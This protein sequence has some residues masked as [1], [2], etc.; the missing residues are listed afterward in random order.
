[1]AKSSIHIKPIKIGSEQHNERIKK[2]TYVREDL[3]HLNSSYKVKTI[4]EA[5]AFIVQNCKE[6]TGRS[7]Q[8]KSTPIR[9]GVLLIDKHHTAEDLKKVADKLEQRFGIKTIQAYC[10]KDEGHYDKFTKEWKPNYH[11]HMVFDWTDHQT[12]KTL[13]L[14]RDDMAKVQTIVAEQLSL[15][16]GISS[17][18]TH[19]NAL[20]FKTQEETKDLEKIHNL[21]NGLAEAQKIVDEIKP[22]K[23]EVKGL[24]E[25]KKGLEFDN[26]LLRANKKHLENKVEEQREELKEVQEQKKGHRLSL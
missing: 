9:E 1:M 4:A 12:G 8:E 13:K 5:K 23:E 10:H 19:L 17:S 15:E 7:I 3:S 21:K 2:L 14:N 16:R 11:A 22:L 20:Q 24:T 18:K 25:A 26:E 6:K